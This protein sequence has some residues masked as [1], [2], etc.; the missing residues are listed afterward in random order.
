MT[1]DEASETSAACNIEI[2]GAFDI[3]NRVVA[4][5]IVTYDK[6]INRAVDN[7]Q[8]MNFMAIR[9]A[10]FAFCDRLGEI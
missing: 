3:G 4:I 9:Y 6:K 8:G 5:A 10:F 1:M 2:R 7:A